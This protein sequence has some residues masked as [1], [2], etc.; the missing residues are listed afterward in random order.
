MPTETTIAQEYLAIVDEIDGRLRLPKVS[1]VWLPRL[2]DTARKSGEFGAVILADGSVGLMFVLLDDTLRAI[3]DRRSSADWVGMD[4][5]ELARG[6]R[7]PDPA[8]KALGLGAINAIG[9]HV[10]KASGFEVDTET[11]SLGSFDPRPEDRFG[12]VGFFPPL[13]RRLRE[14]NVDLTVIELKKELV[15]QSPGFRVTLDP[16][17]LGHCNKILCTSTMLLNDSIDSILRHC[18]HAEEV[19]IIGPGAGFLPDALFARGV[20]TV[21][22]HQV[23]DV[24]GFI[25]RCEGEKKWGGTSRKYCFHR[26]AYPG[27]EAL[28]DNLG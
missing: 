5:V 19:A 15:Q 13:V 23:V 28:L 14:Q 25:A 27:Y 18:G 21:G 8:A 9:Q 20:D 6:F 10:I 24:E 1:Q 7:E 17:A 12:M 22:G 16:E 11:N 4:P 2:R 26:R 3:G